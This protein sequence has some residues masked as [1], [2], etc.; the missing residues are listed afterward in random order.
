MNVKTPGLCLMGSLIMMEIPID[1]KGLVK[2]ATCS[3]WELIVS[4]AIAISACR[5]TNSPTIPADY[6]SDIAPL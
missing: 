2:S 6:S 3:R 4:G 1:M 5:L